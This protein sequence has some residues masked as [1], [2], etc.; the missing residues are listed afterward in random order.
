[1]VLFIDLWPY[2]PL[3]SAKLSCSSEVT[4]M[5]RDGTTGKSSVPIWW[6]QSAPTPLPGVDKVKVYL[7]VPFIPVVTSLGLMF[8]LR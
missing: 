3:N 6:V 5:P 4:L 8:L 7:V 1:M 2:S